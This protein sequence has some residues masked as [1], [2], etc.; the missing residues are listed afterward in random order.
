MAYDLET[1]RALYRKLL[2][3]YP[4]AVRE[5]L[6]ESMEQTFNDL[7]NERK[8]QTERELAGFVLW[9][10][11]ETGIGI[12]TEH[13]LL[14]RQGDAMKTMFTNPRSVAIIGFILA[15][16][17]VA[18]ISLLMLG[19]EPPLGPLA[20]LVEAPPDQPAVAGTLIV[21]GAFLLSLVAFTINLVLIVRNVRAG[22]PITANPVNLVLAAV[23][24]FF[25]TL[26]VGA[27]IVDQYPCWIGVP[28]CD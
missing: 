23:V 22:Q 19:I 20:P 9:M 26:F 15:L 7:C 16:P 27:I 12:A 5:L 21:L 24:L 17:Y 2:A 3:L 11:V 13:A 10:S 25:I 6:G 8:G 14:I 28:N 18:V 4:R 1:V